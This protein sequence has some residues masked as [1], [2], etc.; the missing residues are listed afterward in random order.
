MAVAT[1]TVSL[2]GVLLIG[3]VLFDHTPGQS[4]LPDSLAGVLHLGGTYLLSLLGVA[5]ISMAIGLSQ[6][7]TLAWRGALALLLLATVLTFL[8]GNMVFVPVVLGLS[9]LFIAPYRA[10][11]Y[12]HARLLSEPL[13]TSTLLSL[14]LL[15]GCVVALATRDDLSASW[16]RWFLLL[17]CVV[18]PGGRW[19]WRCCW[20]WRWWGG[21]SG[22][23]VSPF[24]H[25]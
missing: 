14:L 2:C 9:T 15:L 16:C 18:P 13:S 6:R 24:H 12:R 23:P 10:C 3:L 19:H 17:P 11:Y 8:R 1:G 4:M 25:G 5:L 20:H 22:P 7:V 21:C